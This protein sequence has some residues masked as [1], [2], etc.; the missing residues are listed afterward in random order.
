MLKS[1]IVKNPCNLLCMHFD[2]STSFHRNTSLNI[3]PRDSNIKQIELCL[4]KF[5]C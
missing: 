3:Y 4:E 1:W 2:I 5:H